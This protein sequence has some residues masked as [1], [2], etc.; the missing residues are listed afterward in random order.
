V[1]T[2]GFSISSGN[3]IFTTNAMRW[4]GPLPLHDQNPPF[5]FRTLKYLLN[6]A[7]L[8]WMVIATMVSYGMIVRFPDCDH[9]MES[10]WST[11]Q[12]A[13]VA[14]FLFLA[15]ITVF[16]FFIE[17]KLERRSHSNN[18]LI[19]ALLHFMVLILSL[20]YFS[21]DFYNHCGESS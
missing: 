3:D 4:A 19:L 14:Y 16:N 1:E 18:Y 5:M 11:V 8:V 13:S 20:W 2:F 9:V 10:I 12:D 6:L 7:G 15:V 17:R 21:N